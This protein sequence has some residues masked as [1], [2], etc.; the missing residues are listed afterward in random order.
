MYTKKFEELQIAL[1]SIDPDDLTGE[2]QQFSEQTEYS[3][4]DFWYNL[5]S[6]GY[7]KLEEYFIGEKLEEMKA[8]VSKV[9]EFEALLNNLYYE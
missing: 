2:L 8:A 1:D 9:T 6:G 7:L 3:T 4:E 5:T